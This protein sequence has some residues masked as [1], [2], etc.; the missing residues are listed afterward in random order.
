M[1]Y[2]LKKRSV[3]Q[4][5]IETETRVSHS[6]V[7]E[8]IQNLHDTNI[9]SRPRYRGLV[10]SDPYKLII[11]VGLENPMVYV[12][13]YRMKGDKQ[14]VE[15]KIAKAFHNKVKYA[16]TLLSATPYYNLGAEGSRISFYVLDESEELKTAYDLLEEIGAHQDDEYGTI[17]IYKANKGVLYDRKEIVSRHA[18]V[19]SE[20]QLILDLFNDSSL[21][22]IGSELLKRSQ[23]RIQSE[24]KK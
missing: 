2:L 24:A 22:Y 3:T 8:I 10:L 23:S 16:F 19:V 6:Y 13:R 14:F 17:E 15:Q 21:S 12:R 4:V 11:G 1:K 18:F 7:N 20:E 5:E 9:T